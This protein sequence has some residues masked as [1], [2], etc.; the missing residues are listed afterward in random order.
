MTELTKSRG[1]F[2][3]PHTPFTVPLSTRFKLRTEELS[4]SAMYRT[5]DLE[6]ILRNI[7]GRNLQA[8]LPKC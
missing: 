8:K 1:F 3:A 2:E 4:L 5:P 6:S 7:F